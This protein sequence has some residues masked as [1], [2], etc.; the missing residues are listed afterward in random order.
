MADSHRTYPPLEERFWPKVDRRGPDE[1]WLWTGAATGG[2]GAIRGNN[3][4]M[5]LAHR[6]AY[7]L[8]VGPI[9]AGLE[10]DHVAARGCTSTLCV[11]PAH[12]EPVTHQEN[13][14]RGRTA[15]GI[16]ARKTHCKRGHAFDAVNTLVSGGHRYCRVCQRIRA[17]R[18]VP[19]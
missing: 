6:V 19:S 17:G 18:A 13:L 12:L 14:L 3:R 9:P 2:Y 7:E 5:V 8:E 1:C 10:I 16:N 4:E 15:P 11:N